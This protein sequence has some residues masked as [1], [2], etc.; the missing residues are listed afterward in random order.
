MLWASQVIAIAYN[1][2]V[3]FTLYFFDF[4]CLEVVAGEETT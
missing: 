3:L 1:Y 2:N 4:F